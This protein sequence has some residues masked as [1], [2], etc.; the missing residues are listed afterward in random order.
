MPVKS[1]AA[2][3]IADRSGK[4][5]GNG[6]RFATAEEAELYARDL[7]SRWMLVTATRIVESDDPANYRFNADGSYESIPR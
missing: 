1:Y 4:F 3:V 7:A 2:E 6:L 5:C